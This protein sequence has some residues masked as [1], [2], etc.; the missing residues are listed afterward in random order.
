MFHDPL[1][2]ILPILIRLKLFQNLCKQKIEW[3]E[4]ISNEFKSQWDD[5][6]SYLGN[7]KTIEIPRKVLNHDEGDPPQWVELHGFSDANQES[8]G[9]CI[10]LKSIFKSGKVFVHLI[11]SKSRLAPIKE[12]N[13]PRLELLGNLILNRLIQSVRN[14]LSKIL[15]FGD[16]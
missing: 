12:T 7:V 2:I 4:S 3:D 13:I 8:Y 16:F 14:A 15:S 5:V 6:L 9:A 10:Y 1:G 11:A